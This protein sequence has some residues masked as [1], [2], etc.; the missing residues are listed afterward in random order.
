MEYNFYLVIFIMQHF[1]T[2]ALIHWHHQD[3]DRTLPWKEEKDPYKIWLSEII[4]QQTRA[5]QGLPYYERFITA[6]PTIVDLANADDE[7]VFRLWQGLGYYARCRNLLATARM[8]RDT[9]LGV[10]PNQYE[11]IIALK[12]I[13]AYTAAAI[14]SF[15]FEL[16]YAVLDGNVYRVLARYL[17]ISIPID[18]LE[19]KKYFTTKAQELLD[20]SL[21]ALYNQAIMDLGAVVCKPINPMCDICP[22]VTRCVAYAKDEINILPVKTKKI[23]IKKRRFHQLILKFEDK[24]WIR[25]RSAKDIWQDL[26]EFYMIE[27]ESDHINPQ[28]YIATSQI[29]SVI[30]IDKI[31]KQKL[32]HQSITTVFYMVTLNQQIKDLPSDG[33]W[34]KSETLK[35]NAF[36][37]T[38]VS[39]LNEIP[40]F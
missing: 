35:N 10:F 18:S 3:N 25:K 33:I 20:K 21:P 5:A 37:K 23:A 32:T 12:G 28:D 11:Q 17:G 29:V 30:N 22:V 38:I 26:F 34:I 36:P 15:A 31:L 9:Y 24:I 8:V 40:Y 27:S 14:S 6:Y 7:V 1:F 16:P 2:E 13:G 19:G 39:F 4:L